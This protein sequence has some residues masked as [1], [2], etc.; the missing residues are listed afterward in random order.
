MYKI[1]RA[2]AVGSL[3]R[4]PADPFHVDAARGGGGRAGAQSRPVV[5][6]VPFP[7]PRMRLWRVRRL[8]G[9]WGPSAQDGSRRAGNR[10]GRLGHATVN[11][12]FRRGSGRGAYLPSLSFR[13]GFVAATACVVG[14][15]RSM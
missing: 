7:L 9:T 5:A 6:G 8:A 10:P 4:W 1:A 14:Q 13:A 15:W 2:D 3:L 12:A 11:R